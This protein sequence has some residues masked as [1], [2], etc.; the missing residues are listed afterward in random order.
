LIKDA[1]D[2]FYLILLSLSDH[3]STIQAAPGT[4]PS[5]GPPSPHPK[6]W[7]LLIPLGARLP[8]LLIKVPQGLPDLYC[9]YIYITLPSPVCAVLWRLT[10]PSPS[11][12]SFLGCL[13]LY[14]RLSEQN[15]S[16]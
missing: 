10:R 8:L 1:S 9:G 6:C 7:V 14:I 13:L 16:G 15:T 2:T 12:D 5:P 4:Y 3:I 11:Q